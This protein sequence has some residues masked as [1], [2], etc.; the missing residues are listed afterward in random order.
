MALH[1]CSYLRAVSWVL[2]L[3]LTSTLWTTASAQ[4]VTYFS[5]SGATIQDAIIFDSNGNMLISLYE[6][7]GVA[8]VNKTTGLLMSPLLAGGGSNSVTDG[9][10]ATSV[11]LNQPSGL[12][13]DPAGNIYFSEIYPT[14]AVRMINTSGYIY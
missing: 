6:G 1:P 8:R 4:Q 9:A 2:T 5:Q 13:L 11:S 10:L 7:Y 12:T 3:S 14:G